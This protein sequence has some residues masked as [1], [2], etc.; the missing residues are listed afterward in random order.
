L[1][2]IDYYRLFENAEHH[3]SMKEPYDAPTST[4]KPV[5]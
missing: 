3:P 2:L 1:T 4:E 5:Q